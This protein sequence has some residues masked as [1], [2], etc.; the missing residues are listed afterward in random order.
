MTIE[1]AEFIRN[2]NCKYCNSEFGTNFCI[3]LCC[4][5]IVHLHCAMQKENNIC[6]S[7]GKQF[8]Y[9]P[10]ALINKNCYLGNDEI[11]KIAN[12]NCTAKIIRGENFDLI[13]KFGQFLVCIQ[14]NVEV[15]II[16]LPTGKLVKTYSIF[17]IIPKI[18]KIDLI[19][20]EHKRYLLVGSQKYLVFMSLDEQKIMKYDYSAIIKIFRSS[21]IDSVC[22]YLYLENR[23]YLLTHYGVIVFK[24]E[25]S[26]R[27]GFG[28]VVIDD[29]SD[30]KI[31]N[32]TYCYGFYTS[33]YTEMKNGWL[34]QNNNEII[35][36]ILTVDGTMYI[37]RSDSSKIYSLFINLDDDTVP[38]FYQSVTNTIEFYVA[39]IANDK[40]I[41][42]YS[43]VKN[44]YKFKDFVYECQDVQVKNIFHVKDLFVVQT[45]KTLHII[46]RDR[47]IRTIT[48]HPDS[49]L[50]EITTFVNCDNNFFIR[51]SNNNW[52]M[53]LQ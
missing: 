3:K 52:H 5:C 14:T 38:Y 4:N 35:A 25:L 34:F 20:I 9:K 42:A 39:V 44:V 23:L 12:P 24:V 7:C 15:Y 40:V 11:T 10:S 43:P 22:D 27:E 19:T 48:I 21:H 45:Q 31:K 28:F 8:A 50:K 33:K 46:W 6:P 37:Q 26:G 17:G 29:E 53:V 47:I 18:D 49:K 30:S 2:N 13:E 16:Y 1:E 36:L 51:C 41:C 32:F